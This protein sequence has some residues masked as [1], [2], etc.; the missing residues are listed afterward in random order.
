M[1]F[2]VN[3][4]LVKQNVCEYNIKETLRLAEKIEKLDNNAFKYPDERAELTQ[5]LKNLQEKEKN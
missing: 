4:I 1:L 5:M 2:Y 3:Y